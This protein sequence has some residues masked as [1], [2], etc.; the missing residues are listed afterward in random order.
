MNCYVFKKSDRLEYTDRMSLMA[1]KVALFT[2][3]RE[4][5]SDQPVVSEGDTVL[6]VW[7]K[8]NLDT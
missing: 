8:K 5:G 1:E 7:R 6:A 3:I 4:G 2:V